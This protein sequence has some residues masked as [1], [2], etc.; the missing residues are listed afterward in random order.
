[1]AVSPCF[2]FILLDKRNPEMKRNQSLDAIKG[3]LIVLVVLG[4]SLQ[5]GFG[6][7]YCDG[8]YFYDDYLF[9]AIYTFHMP[10]FMLISGY[11]FFYSNQKP[12]MSLI[13]SKFEFVGIPFFTYSIIMYFIWW[14]ISGLNTFYFSDLFRKMHLHLWFL[15]SLLMNCLII[16]CITHTFPKKY[17]LPI[18]FLFCISSMLISDDAILSMHKFILFFFVM[19]YFINAFHVRVTKLIQSPLFFMFFSICYMAGILFY[20]KNVMIYEGGFCVLHN[21]LLD[22]AQLGRNMFRFFINIVSTMWFAGFFFVIIIKSPKIISFFS[23]L[24][25]YTLPIY[26]IQSILFLMLSYVFERYC[27]NIPHNY[28]TPL[29][30]CVIVLFFCWGFIIVFD[31]W[32]LCRFF[33]LGRK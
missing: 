27:I 11:L 33:L 10:L 19:G 22:I 24:G 1:M 29:I 14:N 6:R 28:I 21:N 3:I 23:V 18:V 32:R 17:H 2:I 31:R 15:S 20:D 4:H 8:G 25:R 7:L 30:L 16:G 13:I 5:Y 9:R 26:G 12:F